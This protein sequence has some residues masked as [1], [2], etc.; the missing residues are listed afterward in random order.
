MRSGNLE[1]KIEK[2]FYGNPLTPFNIISR[3]AIVPTEEEI[4]INSRARSAKLRIAEKIQQRKC[5]AVI[6]KT[7]KEIADFEKN[8]EDKIKN[9]D[10]RFKRKTLNWDKVF[11][12]DHPENDKYLEAPNSN[13]E[14]QITTK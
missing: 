12:E 14:E 8:S 9:D 4:E 11:N 2:D 6:L 5:K 1:G 10:R 7:T 13:P 3:K